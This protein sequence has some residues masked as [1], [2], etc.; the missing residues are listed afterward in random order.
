[1]G[2]NVQRRVEM[3]SKT[4]MYAPVLFTPEVIEE[5]CRVMRQALPKDKRQV[6]HSMLIIEMANGEKWSHDTVEEFY[7]D[8]RRN[9]DHA[10]FEARFGGVAGRLELK[11]FGLK[12]EIKVAMP[13]RAEVEK[14]FGVIEAAVVE[15]TVAV[16]PAESKKKGV[17]KTKRYARVVFTPEVIEEAAA[18]T[19]DALP[20]GRRDVN[21][22]Y[23]TI[24]LADGETWDYDSEEEFYAAYRAG[25]QHASL[26][27]HFGFGAGVLSF[28]V[29]GVETRVTVAMPSRV[30]VEKV[31][32]VI[33][34]A[35]DK[36]TVPMPP[37][38]KGRLHEARVFIGHGRDPQW[39]DLKDHLHE[40]HGFY[41]EAY[42]TGVRAGLTVKE[43]LE[44][45]LTG[46]SFA[47][48]VLT[49]EDLDARGELHARDNVIHELG[50]FQG[51]LGWRRAIVLLE[52]GVEEFSNI[53]GLTQ[54]RF[55][56]GNI[57]ETFGE[58][59]ATIR[60]EFPGEQ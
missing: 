10:F 38:E 3:P 47:L 53:Q 44:D 40:K 22:C 11:V 36:C 20:Q 24:E 25:F 51:R 55:S 29:H 37:G 34:L 58:V 52:R 54:I 15:C 18:V 2:N 1:M 14:V 13:S 12:S 42:E 9:F 7:A 35:V 28:E 26:M 59:V 4:K 49:A 41:V 8:Y 56:A 23:L 21:E 27:K 50:L 33:E 60:R 39:R 46:N 30:A 45:M 5:A 57:Q 17:S 32:G 6:Q 19:R 43:V 31:F 48:L 16:P